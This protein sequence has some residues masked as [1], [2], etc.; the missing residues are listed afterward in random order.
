MSPPP[1]SPTAAA[2]LLL[3]LGAAA[4]ASSQDDDVAVLTEDNAAAL[5]AEHPFVLVEF[6]APWC[7]H[8]KKLAPDFAAAATKLAPLEGVALATCDATKQTALATQHGVKGYPT[9]KFF[10]EGKAIDYTGGRR[11]VEI[12]EWVT[13]KTADPMLPLAD[14]A[15][16]EAFR[17]QHAAVAVFFG[18]AEG[19]AHAQ[20][21]AAAS[22]AQ[23][24]VPY[25]H[26]AAGIEVPGGKPAPAL[27][28]FTE[29]A[30]AVFEGE[31]FTQQA[32]EGFVQVEAL[33]P[34]VTF[35][36]ENMAAIFSHSVRT[37]SQRTAVFFTPLLLWGAG[38]QAAP[39][40]AVLRPV[41]GI[42]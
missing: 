26:A 41:R 34:V 23:A 11:E 8:C 1:L 27:V 18:E 13:A 16:L 35:A 31:A 17:G 5:L 25:G 39:A 33:P 32:L 37:P 36:E 42:P 19:E 15:A 28:V 2:L 20:A 7:G 6:F 10:R 38:P 24:G 9:L 21:L 29:S 3:V 4:P 14:A 12:V 30:E 22:A 40:A